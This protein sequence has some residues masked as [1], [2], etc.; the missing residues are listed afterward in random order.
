MSAPTSIKSQLLASLG[1]VG[2]LLVLF[3]VFK[4]I[5]RLQHSALSDYQP[6]ACVGH[7]KAIVFEPSPWA[8]YCQPSFMQPLVST[9]AVGLDLSLPTPRE[10][11]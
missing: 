6:A 2:L 1:V 10:K 8:D 3:Y 9:P 4:P 5:P 7:Q 11:S